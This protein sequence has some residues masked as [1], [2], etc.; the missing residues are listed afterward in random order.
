LIKCYKGIIEK[1]KCFDYFTYLE[2][3]VFIL[4]IYKYVQISLSFL[5]KLKY[6]Y[7]RWFSKHSVRFGMAVLISS[8]DLL[9]SIDYSPSWSCDS[10]WQAAA[11]CLCP[12]SGKNII[13]HIASMGKNWNWKYSLYWVLVPFGLL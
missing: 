11:C 6:I 8:V 13:L 12:K 5:F 4:F 1:C 3:L 10:P 9:Y 2:N 7:K